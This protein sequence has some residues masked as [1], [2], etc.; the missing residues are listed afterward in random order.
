MNVRNLLA[1]GD[2]ILPLPLGL[3]VTIQYDTNGRIERLLMGLDPETGTELP[4]ELLTAVLP[5]ERFPR[6]IPVTQGTT[7]VSGVFVPN[8]VFKE[9]FGALPDDLIEPISISLMEHPD[10]FTF[11]AAA[12]TSHALKFTGGVASQRWL[13]STGFE[14]LPN[15][16]IPASLSADAF[17]K[18]MRPVDFLIVAVLILHK[19]IWKHVSCNLYQDKVVSVNKRFNDAGELRG[20]IAFTSGYKLDVDYYDIVSQNIQPACIVIHDKTS[21]FRVMPDTSKSREP[22]SSKLMCPVCGSA[23]QVVSRDTV[24]S[25]PRCPSSNYLNVVHMLNGLGL[26]TMSRDQY[27]SAFKSVKEVSLA[28]VLD[29]KAYSKQSVK[30]SLPM[31]IRAVVPLTIVR[32]DR[33]I[34]E[35][36]SHCNNSIQSVMYYLNHIDRIVIDLGC[37]AEVQYALSPLQ[38][39]SYIV[40]DIDKLIHHSS[41][42]IIQQDIKFDGPQIFRGR[43]IC[44]TGEFT[45]GTHSEV[46]AILRSYGAA[47]VTNTVNADCILVGD[48]PENVRGDIIRVARNNNVPIYT[49]SSFFGAYKIDEDLI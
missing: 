43:T 19:G 15:Y 24:C 4:T 5:A 45:H 10:T 33:A 23:I 49:E 16:V 18:M 22:R 32:S 21:V 1:P 8:A 35:L 46:S 40:A 28:D 7:W 26:P 38:K 12:V 37:A 39:H 48:I 20:V 29:L 36:C 2:F 41:V 30:I 25:N 42:S 31:L 3:N 13:Q 9:S 17:N 6:T 14:L 11:R 47:V 34:D 27:D 44:I